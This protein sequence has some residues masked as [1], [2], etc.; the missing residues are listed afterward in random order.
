M[1]ATAQTRLIPETLE[2][3]RE[4]L[5]PVFARLAGAAA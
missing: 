1:T 3:T 4:R 2:H 5:R